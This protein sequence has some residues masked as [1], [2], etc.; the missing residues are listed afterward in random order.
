M[1]IGKMQRKMNS[2]FFTLILFSL[3]FSFALI[4]ACSAN[5]ANW[6][7]LTEGSSFNNGTHISMP[8]ADVEVNITRTAAAVYTSLTSEFYI[9]TNITQNATL[10]FVYPSP[11]QYKLLYNS[12][13]GGPN[14][15]MRIF[16]NGTQYNY[17][18]FDYDYFVEQGF[19]DGSDANYSF[20]QPWTRFAVFDIKLTANTTMILS[21]ISSINYI[22]NMDEFDYD[23]IIGSARTFEGHTNERVHFHVV[24]QVPF[25]STNFS[26]NGSLIVTHNGINTDAV[27]QFQMPEFPFDILSFDAYYQ[28]TN[29]IILQELV[30]VIITFII[31][32]AF[33]KFIEK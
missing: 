18:V 5:Y 29:A 1:V 10:A 8:F 13:S 11:N 17:T 26:P 21:T 4:P 27:W 23:Y 2:M 30:I 31:V 25:S 33:Y 32:V 12:S 20:I 9:M 15:D 24:E 3:I 22:A 7:I 6:G 16:A 19:M 14:P 28:S